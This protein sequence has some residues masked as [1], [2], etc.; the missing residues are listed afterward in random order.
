MTAPLDPA[1]VTDTTAA[2]R[3]EPVKV[4]ARLADPVINLD[5]HAMHLDGPASWGAY[6]A[7]LAEYGHGTLPPMTSRR[8]VD[9]PLPLATWTV[10]APAVVD[11]AAVNAAGQVW[12]WACSR[13]LYDAAGYTTVAVRRRPA[14]DEAARYAS[15]GKWHLSSGPLKARDTPAS[16]TL[17][18]ELSWWAL[19]DPEPLRL[20]LARV[21]TLGRH[22]RQGN[23]R[24]L[25][26]TVAPDAAAAQGWRDRVWPDPSGAGPLGTVRAPY[27]H[28][29]RRMPCLA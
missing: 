15:E 11:G 2:A 14:A 6:Q 20:L 5:G 17:A 4:T 21:H 18:G 22:G 27:H 10:E 7:Y 13:A 25:S 23:G 3:W 26:W 28:R 9:W 1:A 12:G 8:A 19:A 29:T 16:A 24:V